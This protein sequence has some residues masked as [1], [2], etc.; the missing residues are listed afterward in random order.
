MDRPADQ[1]PSIVPFIVIGG[2][3]LFG[4][5]PIFGGIAFLYKIFAIPPDSLRANLDEYILLTQTVLTILLACFSIVQYKTIFFGDSWRSDFKKCLITGLKWSIPVVL[6]HLIV[7]SVPSLRDSLINN[8]SNIETISVKSISRSGLNYFLSLA[9]A[10]AILEEL[11]FRGI[12]LKKILRYVNTA[13]SLTISSIIFSLT[14][15]IFYKIVPGDLINHFF[16][17]ILCGAAFLKYRSCISAIVPHLLHNFIW[18]LY[19]NY[20]VSQI[21]SGI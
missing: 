17:G 3:Y 6:Y 2:I 12:L 21:H 13:L 11:L 15:F 8:I 5:I 9:L 1:E 19:I 4:T 20:V 7:I 14:H 16:I 18:F 10:G